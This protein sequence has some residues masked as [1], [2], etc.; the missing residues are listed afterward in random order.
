MF[1]DFKLGEL[2]A[3]FFTSGDPLSVA[4]LAEIVSLPKPQVWEL[5][6]ELKTAYEKENRGLMLREVAEG[7]Q[8]CTKADYNEALIQLV[9]TKELKLSN[10]ALETMALVAFKQPITRGEMEAIRGVK[11][12]GV[13]N[14]LL[15]YG[16]IAEAGRKEAIGRPI[17]YQTTEKFLETFGLKS[18]KDLPELPEGLLDETELEAEAEQIPLLQDKEIKAERREKLQEDLQQAAAKAKTAAEPDPKLKPES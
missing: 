10:A 6:T 12:D 8:L 9:K 14:T 16:L 17:L 15:E 4:Q 18:L 2:E 5:V 3:V 13:V 7:F 1:Q 11:V